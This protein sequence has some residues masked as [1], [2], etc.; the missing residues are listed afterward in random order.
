MTP[1][2][3]IVELGTTGVAAAVAAFHLGLYPVELQMMVFFAAVLT[4]Q[5]IAAMLARM[6]PVRKPDTLE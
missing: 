4:G 1:V 6:A 2:I 5:V 3:E